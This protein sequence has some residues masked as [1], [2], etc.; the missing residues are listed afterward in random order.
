MRPFILQG[1]RTSFANIQ[2][3]LGRKFNSPLVH[4]WLKGAR[5]V[6]SG[7]HMQA[8][9]RIHA[10]DIDLLTEETLRLWLNADEYHR[11]QESR[12]AVRNLEVMLGRDGFRAIMLN[13]LVDKA[14]A[15]MALHAIVRVM[16]GENPHR[17]VTVVL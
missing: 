12:E 3:L 2:G 13:L 8:Q 1:E 9:V 4:G 10:N 14:R 16:I 5:K 17:Q 11:D 15:V 6:Y 7:E